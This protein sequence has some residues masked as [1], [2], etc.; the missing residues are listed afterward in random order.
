[1]QVFLTLIRVIGDFVKK[2]LEAAIERA[3]RAEA[4]RQ[5]AQVANSLNSI[6]F[7]G[8]LV[9]HAGFGKKYNSRFA[10]AQAWLDNEVLKDCEPF[11][12]LRTGTL[13]DSGTL[14]TQIGAGQVKWITPYASRQ[15]KNGRLPGASKT[16]PLRGRYWFERAKAVHKDKWIRGVKQII[17]NG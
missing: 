9:M 13:R 14:G 12:P 3:I 6:R 2:I 17:K 11:T 15:Y 4:A 1:M 7:V 5:A 8:K 16:G 10:K